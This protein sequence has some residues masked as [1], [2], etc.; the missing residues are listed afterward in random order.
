MLVTFVDPF[1]FSPRYT[2]RFKLCRTPNT[3]NRNFSEFWK[4]PELP[5]KSQRKPRVRHF[6]K[7]VTYVTTWHRSRFRSIARVSVRGALANAL[8]ISRDSSAIVKERR[9]QKK[10]EK[11]EKENRASALRSRRSGGNPDILNDA[12]AFNAEFDFFVIRAII[13]V[14]GSRPRMLIRRSSR[15]NGRRRRRR[16]SSRNAESRLSR[17]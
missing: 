6:P 5:E 7:F 9:N 10:T 14:P 13:K 8:M 12:R 15:R 17:D 1:V 4:N 16:N 2:K 11:R 3:R